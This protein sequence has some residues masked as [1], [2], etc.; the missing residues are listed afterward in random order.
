[1]SARTWGGREE[2]RKKE[3]TIPGGMFAIVGKTEYILIIKMGI[4]L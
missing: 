2:S 1:M 4:D 3:A